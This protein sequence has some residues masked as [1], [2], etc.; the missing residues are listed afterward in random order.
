MVYQ[1]AVRLDSPLVEFV[2][3]LARF[4]SKPYQSPD[5][6]FA[7]AAEVGVGADLELM[8]VA[9]SLQGLSDLPAETPLSMNVS[10]ETLLCPEFAS[11]LS[12][13]PLDR[14]I[15]EITGHESVT[16]YSALNRTLQPFRKRGLRVAVGVGVFA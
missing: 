10:P 13:A 9:A 14:L 5:R 16:R 4:Y 12:S 3:A 11:I 7:T 1:P 2:E 8:A 15:V 6:W